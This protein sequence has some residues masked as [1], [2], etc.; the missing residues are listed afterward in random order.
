MK[1]RFQITTVR[2][3]GTLIVHI[4]KNKYIVKWSEKSQS[5]DKTFKTLE[6]AKREIDSY[7]DYLMDKFAGRLD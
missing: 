2:Y 3:I 7:H 1:K 6:E 4:S 5:K